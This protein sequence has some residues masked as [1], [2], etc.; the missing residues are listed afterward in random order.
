M[1]GKEG[2]KERKRRAQSSTSREGELEEVEM[3]GGGEES[4]LR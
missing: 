4:S 2:G 3:E 1:G